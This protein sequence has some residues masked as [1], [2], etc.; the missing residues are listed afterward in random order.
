MRPMLL[1]HAFSLDFAGKKSKKKTFLEGLL[2]NQFR[3]KLTFLVVFFF[4]FVFN[5]DGS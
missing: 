3:Q 2:V 1:F 4:I 5:M